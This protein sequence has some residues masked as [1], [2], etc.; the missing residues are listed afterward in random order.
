MELENVENFKYLGSI[1]TAAAEQQRDVEAR[2]A[3]D[4][5]RCGNLRHLFNSKDLTIHLKLRLYDAAVLSLL[6]YGC[7]SWTL[8]PK[9]VKRLNGANSR[10][11]ASFTGGKSI[12]QEARPATTSFDFMKKIRK[13]RPPDP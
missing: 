9:I 7:E 6:T 1:F 8:S 2:V 11:L 4:T 10:I 5:Q 3:M 13:Q 12:L